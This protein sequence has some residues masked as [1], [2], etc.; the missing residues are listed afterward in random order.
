MGDKATTTIGGGGG[1]HHHFS[2]SS[3]SSWI[4]RSASNNNN[5]NSEE[6]PHLSLTRKEFWIAAAAAVGS[7]LVSSSVVL[8]AFW[9]PHGKPVV[10]LPPLAYDQTHVTLVFHGS[11]GQDPYTDALMRRLR[12][13]T[14]PTNNNNHNE[15]CYTEMVD[16]SRYS[17][18]LVQASHNAERIG[19]L[20]VR[21]LLLE[22]VDHVE[23]LE[24]VHL[25]GI[26]VGSFGADAAAREVLLHA[27]SDRRRRRRRPFVQ[28]TLLDPFTQRGILGFGY[29]DR[30]FGTA[31]DHT[32]QFLNGD[33][34]VPSTNAPLRNAVCYDVTD[35]RP[36]DVFGHDW[37]V[38]FYGQS[39]DCGKV[40]LSKDLQ[41]AMG[42]VTVL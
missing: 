35:L 39:E 33:D 14:T 21:Q 34:P 7:V 23:R 18:N 12:R 38:V 26:S 31:A 13:T 36:R 16:W 19:K 30:V 28:L 20:V 27:S 42:S 8:G 9:L 40:M 11:G 17:G 29:G 25:I 1:W 5:N 32:Q 37:P 10:V 24:T 3:S 4:A 15:K 22:H 6:V 2:S 41:G